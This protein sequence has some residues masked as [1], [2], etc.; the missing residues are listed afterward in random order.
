MSIL[1]RYKIDL[2]NLQ[3]GLAEHLFELDNS[4][5]EAIEG[6]LVKS[7]N[8]NV[9]VRI[10]EIAGTFEFA[11]Q[12]QGIVQ[13]VCDRC[14]DDMDIHI[15]AENIL[16]VK[17]GS[18]FE[19]DGETVVIPENEPEMN[20]AWPIYEMVVLEIPLTHVHNEGQ[21]NEEM[22]GALNNLLVHTQDEVQDDNAESDE[23]AIDPRWNELKK[24]LDNN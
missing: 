1:D 11:F 12:V 13:V 16:N 18:E 17:L 15:H 6:T 14:L 3:N 5:F 7:G 22:L 8:V 19:D 21:C 9:C 24:I 20:V 10:K 23:K 2:R 4:F